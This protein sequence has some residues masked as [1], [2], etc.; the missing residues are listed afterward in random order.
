MKIDILRAFAMAWL[1]PFL[2]ACSTSS[3]ADTAMTYDQH[4]SF[5]DVHK[6]YIEPSSRTDA[7]T[8]TVSDGQIARIDD[9][10]AQELTRR[11]FEVVASS[12]QADLLLTWYL[13]TR[14]QVRASASDCDGCDMTAEGG[15]RYAK[16]TLIVDMTDPMRNQ[17]VWRSVLQTEL[18]AQPGSASAEQARQAAAAAIFAHFPPQ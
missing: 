16:G 17:P 10:L 18:T 4:F 6:I 13:V 15:A 8:I 3:P 1:Y 7:A 11:G 14:D 9:A 12:R 2:A 5:T